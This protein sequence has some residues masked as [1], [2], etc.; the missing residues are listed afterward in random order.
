MQSQCTLVAL[1]LL[2]VPAF[3]RAQDVASG[4]SRGET[5]PALKVFDLTGEHQGKAVEYAAERKGRP[6]VYLFVAADKFDRP[7]NRF[8][9]ALDTAAKKDSPDA[10]LVAVWLTEDK[11]KTKEYLPRVQQ[12]VRFEAT[13][14]TCYRG[15]KTGPK[16]WGINPDAHL[17]VVVANQGKVAAVFGYRSVN[18]TDAPAVCKELEKARSQK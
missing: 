18:E 5:V 15:D 3:G 16:G 13:A 1:A 9:K 10:Y 8:L 12:S 7:M 6:T 11:E 4:P 17:T 14:L 2:V